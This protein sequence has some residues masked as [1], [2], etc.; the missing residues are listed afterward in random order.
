MDALN[1]ISDKIMTLPNRPFFMLDTDVAELYEIETKRV[2]EAVKRNPERFPSDFYFQL[3]DPECKKLEKTGVVFEVATCDLKH[4]RGGRRY[5]PY[6][7][8]REGCNMLATILNSA[9]AVERSIQ[10]IRAFTALERISTQKVS[11]DAPDSPILPNGLQLVMLKELYGSEG[12]KEILKTH[13]GISPGNLVTGI[14]ELEAYTIRKANPNKDQRDKMIADLIER[15]VPRRFILH[16]SMLTQ[17]SIR[18]F[19][20]RYYP[21]D[22]K[23]SLN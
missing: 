8:T 5:L 2:N 11:S 21:K 23:H 18:K 9:I 1:I 14:S 10:I 16:A 22:K 13:Y 4:N 12:L 6:G 20:R 19:H 3:T 7:F 17:T 15:G